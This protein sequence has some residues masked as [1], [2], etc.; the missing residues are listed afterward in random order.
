MAK[1]HCCFVLFLCSVI[2]CSAQIKEKAVQING[3]GMFSPVV[4]A[5]EQNKIAYGGYL[6]LL[7]KV[8]PHHFFGSE[9]GTV[10]ISGDKRESYWASPEGG[11]IN[12]QLVY[13]Y[14]HT[15]NFYFFGSG[16][17][18]IMRLP[19]DDVLGFVPNIQVGPGY[20]FGGKKKLLSTEL[21]ANYY[22]TGGLLVGLRLGI[23]FL[24]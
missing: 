20:N 13:K 3:G 10:K 4:I 6:R 2:A 16:G 11:G 7:F 17:A 8:S 12:F 14:Q 23:N 5:F 9:L 24:H 1:Y 19:G 18:A 22:P 21:L 15:Q